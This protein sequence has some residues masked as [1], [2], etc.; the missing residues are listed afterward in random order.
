MGALSDE[1]IQRGER[2]LM[3]WVVHYARLKAK[4]EAQRGKPKGRDSHCDAGVKTASLS[5]SR[6]GTNEVG[7]T[8]LM[9][10]PGIRN[11]KKAKSE[12]KRGKPDQ[13]LK[14]R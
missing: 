5:L 8:E 6:G 11:G 13:N 12:A 10:V 4:S 9:D 7:D 1:M 14:V 2:A 3:S